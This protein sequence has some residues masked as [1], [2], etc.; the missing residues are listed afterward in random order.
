[1]QSNC[2][3]LRRKPCE[4]G[5]NNLQSGQKCCAG[6]LPAEEAR[7]FQVA[8]SAV[9]SGLIIMSSHLNYSF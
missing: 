8:S 2:S 7:C 1:M 3:G 5:K 9:E 4:K 6:Q